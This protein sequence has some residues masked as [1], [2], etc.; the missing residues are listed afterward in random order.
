M[1]N[2]RILFASSVLIF[3]A[4]SQ[5]NA[6]NNNRQRER[7]EPPSIDELFEKMDANEDGK[8][9]QEEV[10]GPLSRH[11]DKIDANEDGFL[12]REELENVPKPERK[13][14]PRENN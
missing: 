4:I 11:F 13:G 5:S 1:K 3:F 9:S 7:R 14:A 6:Q 10:K 2:K 12:T 8:L